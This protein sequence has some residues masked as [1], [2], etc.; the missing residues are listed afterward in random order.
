MRLIWKVLR[1]NISIGQLCGF[2]LA[3]IIGLTII[4]L[5]LQLYREHHPAGD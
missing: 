5:G 1:Q 2:V 4:V 3:N